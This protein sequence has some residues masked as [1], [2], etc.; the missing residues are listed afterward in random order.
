MKTKDRR[1]FLSDVIKVGVA[2]PFLTPSLISC[3]EEEGKALDILILGGTSFLGPHQIT[4]ALERGHNVSTFTRGKTKPSVHQDVFEQ[5]EMLIGDRENDL[6]ALEK[7]SWDVV[8]DNSGRNVEWTK[9]SAQLLKKSCKYYM[10]TSSTG[11][12]Y[13]YLTKDIKEDIELVYATPDV[14]PDEMTK[15]EYD[16][17]VMKANS[18]IEAIKAFGEKRTIIVRPTYMIGPGDKTDRFIHW[19]IRLSRGGEVLVPGK[20]NDPV[21]Y[22]DVRDVAEFMIRLAENKTVGTFNA[23]GPESQQFMHDFVEEASSAFDVEHTF[24]KIP[25]DD[26]LVEKD[27]HYIVPWIM[28]IGN[29]LGSSETSNAKSLA[30]GLTLRPLVTSVKEIHE[31]WNSGVIDAERKNKVENGENSIL[32]REASIIAAWKQNM[33]M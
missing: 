9:R 27:I 25:D 30:N 14:L 4:Y 32:A 5:V 29:N 11:V 6:K 3:S 21:Q 26:F 23:V 12:Y 13:P 16:Y 2:L 7:R 22:I 33:N 20:V 10:Y 28:P 15:M 18:E 17:G 31:W 8:I 24:I 19:P 1:S